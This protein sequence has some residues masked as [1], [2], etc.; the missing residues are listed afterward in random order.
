MTKKV[1]NT[2][3]AT[4]RC[5]ESVLVGEITY[6]PVHDEMIQFRVEGAQGINRFSKKVWV[7]EYPKPVL[8]TEPGSVIIDATILG[9]TGHTALLRDNGDWLTAILVA[10]SY[11][12]GPWEITEF[13]VAKVVA[14][15]E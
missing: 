9:R 7:P 4:I 1:W 5:G 14:A 12:H 13:T 3:P 2:G 8:P 11:A 10:G 15:D 6:A